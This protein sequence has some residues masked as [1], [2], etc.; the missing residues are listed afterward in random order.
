MNPL[1]DGGDSDHP[2]RASASLQSPKCQDSGSL[3][4]EHGQQKRWGKGGVGLG[5]GSL[6][7]SADV[8]VIYPLQL[9][10]EGSE[11]LSL[12]GRLIRSK[13]G[14]CSPPTFASAFSLC[15]S[16][17]TAGP[18]KRAQSEH[19]HSDSL[20]DYLSGRPKEPSKKGGSVSWGGLRVLGLLCWFLPQ[21]VPRAL[22]ALF[23]KRQGPQVSRETLRES[24][25]VSRGEC[26]E[27][28]LT[29]RS[30]V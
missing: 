14:D 18:P 11:Q 29:E 16:L 2:S 13:V 8:D 30:A 17:R 9:T 5:R 1:R 3:C 28:R 19:P 25:V 24:R 22:K 23:P 15:T 20:Q 4:R 26:Q 12:A 7:P 27:S 10:V 6:S 21:V